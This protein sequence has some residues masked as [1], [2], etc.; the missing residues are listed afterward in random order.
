MLADLAIETLLACLQ[1]QQTG[2][3][4][5]YHASNMCNSMSGLTHQ[6]ATLSFGGTH[7]SQLCSVVH[8]HKT[9]VVCDVNPPVS[10]AQLP[11]GHLCAS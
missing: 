7:H 1:V 8:A 2:P 5:V 10:P 11:M 4:G 9:N 6:S 3:R